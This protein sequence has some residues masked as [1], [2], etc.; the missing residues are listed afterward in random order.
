MEIF[1]ANLPGLFIM[2]MAA[3]RKDPVNRHNLVFKNWE[4]LG[5]KNKD[6]PVFLKYELRHTIKIYILNNDYSRI[7]SLFTNLSSEIL[8]QFSFFEKSL[9]R[10]HRFK[11][12][13]LLYIN[14]TK[15][16]WRLHKYPVT[17]TTRHHSI[18]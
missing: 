4:L 17:D 7:N 16:F 1:Q 3:F 10:L 14:Y 6:Y 18:N 13:A 15:I 8:K 5:K 9:Y 2:K 11:T 12:L